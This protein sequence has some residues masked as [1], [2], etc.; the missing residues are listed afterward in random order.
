MRWIFNESFSLKCTTQLL[1][2]CLWQQA[3]FL[4]SSLKASIYLWYEWLINEWRIHSQLFFYMLFCAVILENTNNLTIVC[5]ML[6]NFK[7]KFYFSRTSWDLL[8]SNRFVIHNCSAMSKSFTKIHLIKI[9]L[10]SELLS[11]FSLLMN[12]VLC[13]LIQ[14]VEI[15]ERTKL[16]SHFIDLAIYYRTTNV[17]EEPTLNRDWMIQIHL[18]ASHF[19]NLLKR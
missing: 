9:S 17:A 11:E 13:C 15:L 3:S 16:H 10:L 7:L 12:F 6:F 5:S 1:W 8:S 19:H 4:N 2:F 14:V 18:S